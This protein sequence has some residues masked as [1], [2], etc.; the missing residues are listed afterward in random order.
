MPLR[1]S[2]LRKACAATALLALLLTTLLPSAMSPLAGGSAGA[3]T[4]AVP[5]LRVDGAIGPASADYLHKGLARAAA[6]AAPLLVIE[7]DTPGGLDTSMRAIIRDI[8]AAPLPV[9]VFVAPEGAR[10]ASAGTYL[11]YASHIAAMAPATNLGAATPVAIGIGGAQPGRTAPRQEADEATPEAAPGDAGAPEAPGDA[12]R[13][14]TPPAPFP[15]ASAPEPRPQAAPA[16]QEEAAGARARR[17]ARDAAPAADAMSAKSVSDAA[18]YLR[19]LAQLR[20]RDVDFAERAVR[21]AASL[22]AEEALA[23]GVIDLIAVDVADLLQKLDGRTVS[24]LDGERTLATAGLAIERI[25]PDWRNRVLAVLANPQVAL[26]LMMIGIY[27]LFFEFT[28]P[29]FGV[30][31]VAGAIS[32]LIA[33]YAFQL[34]P[35][36]WAGVLL[37]AIGAALMLAEAFLP[38][39]GVLGVGG[40]IAFVVGGLFLIDSEVPGF[41]IPP[42]LVIGLALASA[43]ILLAIGSLAARSFK[44]PVV[45]GRE[46]MLGAPATVLGPAD[47]GCWWVAVHGENWRA[48]AAVALAAGDTVRVERIDGLVLEV[49]PAGASPAPASAPPPAPAPT[50][51]PAPTSTPGSTP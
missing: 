38:S 6:G 44:R 21:E 4:G 9:A 33:L 46:Q 29:G 15:P 40:I 7:L 10:A 22:S 14:P 24:V 48:R 3:D 28:S 1:P 26:I 17:P 32:L 23:R 2:R 31:G 35:V 18:A 50:P 27:G 36:N 19:S 45:S 25:D 51:G 42:A 43:A 20:G 41:G 30:P 37:L 16:G 8:L 13:A 12:G 39:F 47:A 11:L 34:L 5:V 49:S